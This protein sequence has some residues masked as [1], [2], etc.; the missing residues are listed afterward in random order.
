MKH[1]V[2]HQDVKRREVRTA[3]LMLCL[4]RQQRIKR[5]GECASVAIFL[6]RKKLPGSI[7][8]PVAEF[9]NLIFPSFKRSA[10]GGLRPT[11]YL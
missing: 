11:W 1:P 9:P 10:S 4:L 6:F 7:V 8:S 3:S 2:G 5:N